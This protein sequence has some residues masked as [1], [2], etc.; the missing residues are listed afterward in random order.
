MFTESGLKLNKTVLDLYFVLLFLHYS[1]YAK[2]NIKQHKQ[3]LD[4]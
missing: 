2:I 3:Y 1:D 4:L